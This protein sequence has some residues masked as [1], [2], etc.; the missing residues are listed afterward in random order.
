M[1][2]KPRRFPLHLQILVAIGVGLA[3]GPLLGKQA[4]PLGEL[5]KLVIQLIKATAT[6]LLFFAIVSATLKTE[7]R[8]RAALKLLSW[9]TLNACLALLLGLALSNLFRPG[10]SLLGLHP[11]QTAAAAAYASKKLDLLA[12][13]NGVVPTSFVAPFAEN[14]VLGVI[15]LALLVGL[16]LRFVKREQRADGEAHYLAVESAV[17]T[18]LRLMEVVLGWVI[19]LIPLAIFGVVA[20]AVG[21]HGYAPLRGLAAYVAVGLGGLAL[22]VLVTYQCLLT[23][24]ARMP[25][26][27]FWA[28]AKEPVSYAAGANSSLATLPV[29]LRALDRLGV[30]RSAS[31]LGACVGTNFNNDGI[32]L[33]EGMAVLFVAQAAGI[34]LSVTQ[35]L[36][37]A[38]ICLVAAMGVAGVPEAGFVSLALV[39]NT[40]GL[41][42]ELLPLLLT[43]DWIIARGRS[44]VNVLSDMVLSI[45]LV[46]SAPPEGELEPAEVVLQ[47]SE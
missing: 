4:Q 31:A 17:T 37:A 43:V 7:V 32:I 36:L 23:W 1:K 3:V 5:G 11:N 18:L 35:Q 34:E 10:R 22:H 46:G 25:L 12:T 15:L 33:Y 21:E 44:V 45:L 13:L 26:C 2:L 38:A 40:V 24:V 19:R 29:T 42:L 16:G 8:G 28:A 41:P 14:L 39:L 27:K 6:P 47:P 30:P 20:R 9:A